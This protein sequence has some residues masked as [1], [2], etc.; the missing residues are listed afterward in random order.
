MFERFSQD[1]RAVVI[2]A[3]EHALRRHRTRAGSTSCSQPFP[4]A[5]RPAWA[6]APRVSHRNLSRR[7]SCAGSGWAPGPA[8]RRPGPGRAGHHRDR[9]GCGARQDRVILRPAG[10]HQR[11]PGGRPEPGAGARVPGRPGWCA[12][13]G[14]GAA[15]GGSWRRTRRV[16]GRPRLPGATVL[17]ARRPAGTSRSRLR[18]RRSSSSPSAR[19]SP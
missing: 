1:A 12:T 17:P 6:C 4:A 19:P 5:S 15:P 16:P 8:V 14:A 18:P 13:G 2:L 9:P 7:R 10:P 3:R 11:R